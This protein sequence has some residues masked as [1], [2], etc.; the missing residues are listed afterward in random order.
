MN[1]SLM[2]ARPPYVQFEQRPIEDRE[3]T[4]KAGGIVMKDEDWVVVMQAGSKDTVEKKAVEWLASIEKLAAQGTY[5]RE[6]AQHFKAQY[7]AFKEGQDVPELGL[8]VK[9]WPS[10]TAAQAANLLAARVRTVEDVAVMNEETINRVGMGSRELKKKAQAY[11]DSREANKAAEMITA[12]KA[13]VDSKDARLATLEQRLAQ[14]EKK[15]A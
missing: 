11:L 6:W 13:E 10:V 1:I 14:L 15:R 12:L 7:N 9:H 5:P 3:Q 8:S 4:I 2:P